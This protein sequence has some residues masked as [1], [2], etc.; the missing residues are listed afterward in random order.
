MPTPLVVLYAGDMHNTLLLISA[1]QKRQLGFLVS[2][3]LI[4]QNLLQLH[5]HAVIFSLLYF[6]RILLLEENFVQVQALQQ[7]VLYLSL[8]QTVLHRIITNLSFQFSGCFLI[9][10]HLLVKPICPIL[11][12]TRLCFRFQYQK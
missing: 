11:H 2:F 1:L 3:Y 6:L 8:S 9:T 5:M 7:M 4:V 10:F 12:F